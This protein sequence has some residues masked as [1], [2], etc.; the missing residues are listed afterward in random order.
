MAPVAGISPPYFKHIV[1]LVK[2]ATGKT[3]IPLIDN[4]NGEL[5]TQP[6]AS[7]IQPGPFELYLKNVRG[8]M[9]LH[10]I[11]KAMPSFK[12]I[13]IQRAIIVHRLSDPDAIRTFRAL[14]RAF[15]IKT[16]VRRE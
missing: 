11:M 6:V 13:T 14:L 12:K 2:E 15:N 3:N 5:P 8:L 1:P 9:P 4:T 16:E 10:R 7:I